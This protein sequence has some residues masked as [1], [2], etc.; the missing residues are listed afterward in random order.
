L[1]QS[2]KIN[3]L[4]VAVL[5][6]IMM[7][8]FTNQGMLRQNVQTVGDTVV[9]VILPPATIPTA[10][11][12]SLHDLRITAT[13]IASLPM[14]PTIANPPATPIPPASPTAT[15]TPDPLACAF[16]MAQTTMKESTPQKYTFSEPQ[17]VLTGDYPDIAGW[18]PDNQ[19]VIIMSITAHQFDGIDGYL[20]TIE[21]FNP[22]TKETHVYATRRNFGDEP[23]AWNSALNAIIYP[24]PN[25]LGV[26]KTTHQL[27]VTRQIRISDGNPD[28]TQ[29]LLDGLLNYYS[30]MAIKPDGSQIVYWENNGTQNYKLYR[31][32]VSHE[33]LEPEQLIPFDPALFGNEGYPLMYEMSWRPNASQLFLYS[34]GSPTSQ[35]LLVDANTGRSCTLNFDGWVYFARWSPNGRYLAV[36]TQKSPMLS[37]WS[38]LDLNVLDTVTGK[39]YK[40]DSAKI[41]PPNRRHTV[42]DLSWAPDNHHLAIIGSANAVGTSPPPTISRLYLVDFLSGEVDNLFPTYQFDIGWWG[43]GLA[44]SPD[45]TKIM[46]KC[47]TETEGRLCL[48]SVQT[49]GE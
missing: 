48:V 8:L 40:I 27:T 5:V 28:T 36:I 20:Q 16:P 25:V 15:S 23:L 24:A 42:S 3:A 44:W 39:L 26:D 32:K 4:L 17:V 12:A 45:G 35:T 7:L 6:L 49:G 34:G 33:P 46:A 22:E 10:T 37:L 38:D 9:P 47:P 43:R 13:Y 11:T 41:V 19:N 2:N 14:F 29:L 21:L 30:P 18:L 1:K 31:H